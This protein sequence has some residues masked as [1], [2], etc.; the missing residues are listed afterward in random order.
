MNLLWH[1]YLLGLFQPFISS[2]HHKKQTP[3]KTLKILINWIRY[4]QDFNGYQS[5]IQ[6]NWAMKDFLG[7]PKKLFPFPL[8]Y[9][10]PEGKNLEIVPVSE[11]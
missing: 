6:F 4:G 7:F 9:F 1:Y 2:L 8:S 3:Q 11:E 5:Q 10:S